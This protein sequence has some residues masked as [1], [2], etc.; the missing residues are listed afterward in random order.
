VKNKVKVSFSRTLCLQ[1]SIITFIIGSLYGYYFPFHLSLILLFS[2]VLLLVGVVW[3]EMKLFLFCSL[4]LIMSLIGVIRMQGVLHHPTPQTVDFYN[5][6]EVVLS[7]MISEL[8][9][10]RPEKTYLTVEI[11]MMF[12]GQVEM[13]NV[14]GKVLLHTLAYPG[15]DYGDIVTLTGK[16]LSPTDTGSN[17]SYKNYLAKDN[18]YSVMAY[19]S[20]QVT[21]K[22][23]GNILQ[24]GLYDLRNNMAGQINRVFPEPSSSLLA[25]LL[26]GIRKTMPQE[27]VD[28]LQQT[29]LIHIIALSGFNITII[30]TFIAGFL[31]VRFRRSLRFI[32]AMLFVII[33]TILVGAAPSVVRASVMGILGL[34]ALTVGRKAES[35]SMLLLTLGI[36]IMIHPVSLVLDIGFQLSFLATLGLILLSP[37]L[38]KV[39][40]KLP[41]MWGIKDVLIT[42]LSAQIAVLPL[43][44]STFERFSVVSL[45]CNILVLAF[46]PLTMLFGFLAMMVSNIPFMFLIAKVIGFVAFILLAYIILIVD[47]FASLPFASFLVPWWNTTISFV[48]YLFLACG[49]FIFYRKNKQSEEYSE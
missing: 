9:D 15:Y 7:G 39:F 5:G 46:I 41:K 45:L 23:A 1:F 10:I 18:I 14:R 3:K 8:P 35:I 47:F 48:F 16:L 49:L 21:E 4:L 38:Q 44:L 29:G 42:S 12:N 11:Q 25:G 2:G 20:I 37:V 27:L 26:L 34:F 17:F 43:L 31:F 19:P 40:I 36:M 24:S 22:N 6:Q 13:Q 28:H 32:L 30:I 33:F